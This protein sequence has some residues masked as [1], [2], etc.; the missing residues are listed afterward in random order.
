MI[1]FFCKND[2]FFAELLIPTPG[3]ANWVC[4]SLIPGP[5]LANSSAG[6]CPPGLGLAPLA[7][8]VLLPPLAPRVGLRAWLRLGGGFRGC[9]RGLG[10]PGLGG[11]APAGCPGLC[12]GDAAMAWRGP[13]LGGKMVQMSL[14]KCPHHSCRFLESI[15][16]PRKT[17]KI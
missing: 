17:K 1:V 13:S 4:K 11:V 8:W 16:V 14:Y 12:A 2:C 15:L 9:A 7:C 3:F 6:W 5:G 10:A